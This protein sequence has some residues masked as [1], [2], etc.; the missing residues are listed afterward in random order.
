M[1]NKG[2]AI[3]GLLTALVVGLAIA[4]ISSCVPKVAPPSAAPTPPK[5]QAA[6]APATVPPKPV[7]AVKTPEKG[8]AV[9]PVPPLT[10]P[11]KPAPQAK[12]IPDPFEQ[13]ERRVTEAIKRARESVVAL[14]YTAADSDA[15]RRASGVVI[16]SEGDVLS[17][18]I[19]APPAASPVVATVASGY[20]LPA[21]W[22]A[23]DP[24][25][26]LTLLKI[27]PQV[28]RPAVPSPRGAKLGNSVMVI[29]NPF[30]FAH[31]INRGNVAGLNRRL[32]LGPRQL[33]GLI[34][35]NVS[36]HRGDS[37]AM[38]A[39]MSGG[40][41]GVI[42]SGL[43][44]PGENEG[45]ARELDHDLGFAI[46]ARDALWVAD[47]LRTRQRVDRAYLGVTMDPAPP[48]LA[49]VPEGAV[50]GRV[51]ADTP[52]ERA[53]LKAGDRVVAIDGHPVRSP[54]DLTDR[55]DHTPADAEITLDLFRGPG[56]VRLTFRTA[57]RPPFEPS[58]PS[59]PPVKSKAKEPRAEVPAE[60]AEMIQRLERRIEE[61]EKEKSEAAATAQAQSPDRP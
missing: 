47:Q 44:S 24:E 38:L 25:T 10:G 4:S 57:R 48:L 17:V 32:V 19:D 22:V 20:S 53:G 51:V 3:S 49:G 39:D 34:Q 28:A 60:V 40:W 18:R 21:E 59:A 9:S 55:L 23:A 35:V 11:P 33:G 54:Y 14:E 56:P 50:L 43:A 42:R 6:P 13:F 16:S 15:R 58:Q 61:L 8:A 7:I 37:G 12:A 29:G 2:S 52:A 46:P 45:M 26:G 36:L 30:G 41:L 31:S 27:A 1:I 5:V